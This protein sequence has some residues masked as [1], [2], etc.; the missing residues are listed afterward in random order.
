MR[1][2]AASD[3]LA[4][5]ERGASRHAIDRSV[6]LCA[7]A[8]PDL[9]PDEIADLPLGRVTASLLGLREISFGARIVGHVD[10][11]QCGVRLELELPSTGLLQREGAGEGSV[12]ACGRRLRAPSL[13]DLAAV[14][15]E[16][17][18]GR[19]ARHLLTRC[20]IE[21]P[22]GSVEVTDEILRES[23]EALETLDPNAEL[24]LRMICA[25]CGGENIAQLDVGVL[26]WD[27]I[28]GRA[29]ALLGEVDILAR[30]YG[31]TE[32][33]VLAL[34]PARRGAYLAMVSG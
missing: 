18:T 27:E 29:R 1:P 7:W 3:V 28:D 31:W 10:C 23:E 32:S 13:R 15:D 26:L 33:E 34:S 14:A 25:D 16:A 21:G 2:L 24:R 19:A 9:P 6:L 4:L 30:A 11:T 8:R 17:D 20:T 12:E 22:A 5:W